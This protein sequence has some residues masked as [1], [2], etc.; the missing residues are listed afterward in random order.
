[1]AGGGNKDLIP[2]STTVSDAVASRRSVRAFLDRPVERAAIERVLEKAQ[3]APS[4]GNIQPW[5]A[6][7]LAGEPLARLSALAAAE[8]PK[9][10][11][12][13]VP[14]YP[15]YPPEADGAYRERVF[16]VGE[17]LYASLG[18]SR[19]D[20]QGRLDQF[21]RNYLAFGAPVLMLVHMPAYMGP[22]QWSDTGMWLQ[23]VMLLLREEGLDS[24]PQEA[25][26]NYSPQVRQVA[27]IPDDHIFFCGLAI[28]YR[29]PDAAV[30]NFEVPRA[31]L[32]ELVQFVGFE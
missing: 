1:M 10:R 30:N 13:L 16:G 27:P 20:K 12:G 8:F 21:A 25:W 23:A 15:I 31:A 7:L 18:I 26:A 29:D 9:G 28:G 5:N 14:E 6:I 11:A 3:R 4:G 22:P 32:D 19:E 2:P 17:A 24:C